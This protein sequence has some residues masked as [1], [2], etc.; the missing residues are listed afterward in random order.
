MGNQVDAFDAEFE[1]LRKEYLEELLQTTDELEEIILKLESESDKSLV[2]KNILRKVHSV[3]GAAG[4][5]GFP[6]ISTVCHLFED[7]IRVCMEQNKTNTEV[8]SEL[9]DFH[10]KLM[11]ALK[12]YKSGNNQELLELQNSLTKSPVDNSEIKEIRVLVVEPA[13]TVARVIKNAFDP[14]SAKVSVAKNGYDALGRLLNE[15]FDLILSSY[16]LP[17][18]DGMTLLQTIKLNQGKNKET[19]F[20]IVSSSDSQVKRYAGPFQP[21]LVI[22]KDMHVTE[23]IRDYLKTWK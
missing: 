23:H 19:K 1:A 22:A 11:Q 2:F 5:Y 10:A 13:A 12:G 6:V 18:M 8:V 3:K 4:S 21:N 7:H 15:E 16:Q 17:L 9:L 20:V 14:Q